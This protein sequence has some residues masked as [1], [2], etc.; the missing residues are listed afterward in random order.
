MGMGPCLAHGAFITLPYM[1]M[2]RDSAVGSLKDLLG[3]AAG[4]LLV[5]SLAGFA[6]GLAGSAVLRLLGSPRMA[7][8]YQGVLG[9]GLVL[10]AMVSL[11]GGGNR[12]CRAVHRGLL[13]KPG[14]AMTLA[15]VVATLTPCPVMLGL[16]AYCM[17]TGSGLHGLL[18]GLAFGLGSAL[19]PLLLGG[20]LLVWAQHRLAP[21]GIRTF[22][23]YL[24]GFLLFGYGVLLLAGLF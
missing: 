24:G 17:S 9:S 21:R 12:L 4:R 18:A 23:R 14:K 19:S 2:T 5:H 11:L 8:I 7:A 20:P 1:A 10:L 16:M 6:C 22:M 13:K 3:F 15:G